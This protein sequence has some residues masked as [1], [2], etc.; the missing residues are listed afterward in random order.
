VKLN[1][2]AGLRGVCAWWVVF[3]HSLALMAPS[4]QGPIKDFLARGYLAVDLFFL[5]SG[6]VIFL[7]YHASLANNFQQSIGKFYW[8]RLTRIYPLH[9]LMLMAYL[10]LF[11]AFLFLSSSG[12]AP[13]SYSWTSFIQSLFLVHMWVGGDLS[14]NVPSWSISS[15]WFVYLFFPLMVLSLRK[16]RG[17]I[18]VHLL[19]IVL[20]AVLLYTVYSL[21][22]LRSLGSDIPRMALVRTMLEFL[23]GVFVGSL[24]VNHKAFLEKWRTAALAGFVALCALYSTTALPDYAV[25][26]MA[27]ALLIAYLSVSTSWIAAA[28]ST[29][30]LVYLGEISYSTYMVHYLVY[31]LLKAGFVSDINQIDQ[32]YVWLSFA[33]VF[34]LSV[35]LHHGVDMPSQK[36]FRRRPQVRPPSLQPSQ[37]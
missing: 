34:A 3:Y 5:L 4:V 11:G 37:Q 24:F 27:F 19:A 6:F 21:G 8:N 14:W 30:P 25:M 12:S 29:P 31:D 15:E 20:L 32:I 7:S 35:L 9:F 18:P 23:M 36:F 10:G 2:L 13:S 33:I 26:P 17:G 28:L 22:G 16:L 1:Q